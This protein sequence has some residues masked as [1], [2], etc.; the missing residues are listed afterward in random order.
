MGIIFVS[1]TIGQSFISA[2][3]NVLAAKVFLIKCNGSLILQA[4][5]LNT[6]SLPC[7]II[8]CETR[9]F[10]IPIISLK[11]GMANDGTREYTT[12][13]HSLK[14]ALVFFYYNCLSLGQCRA[15]LHIQH[16]EGLPAL[17]VPADLL[18]QLR[19]FTVAGFSLNNTKLMFFFTQFL[20]ELLNFLP[21]RNCRAYSNRGI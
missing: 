3:Q 18:P 20:I 6:F 4:E 2:L 14:F 13:S 17:A 1:E 11:S 15:A 7:K 12:S 21:S 16:M 19:C 8:S 9:G 5:Y 10:S